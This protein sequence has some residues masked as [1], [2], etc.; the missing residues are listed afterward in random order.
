MKHASSS[1]RAPGRAPFQYFRILAALLLREESARRHAPLESL[2]NLLEPILLVSVMA[3]AR[4][5]LDRSHVS[6]LGESPLLFYATGFFADYLFLYISRRMGGPIQQPGRRFPIEQR[7][8][9][10]IAHVILR[11]M[12]YSILGLIIFGFIYLFVTTDALPFDFVSV[13]EACSAMIMLGFGWGI[14]NVT[15]TKLFWPWAYIG[16]LF[17]RAMVLL[18]GVFFLPDF[19]PP[20][21]RYYI[22]L[23]PLCHGIMLFRMGFYP[24]YPNSMFDPLY[25][26]E[27]AIFSLLAGLMLERITR[28]YE[29]K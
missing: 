11:A 15:V 25:L 21:T 13:A 2:L 17:Y 24:E 16:P 26:A 9:H 3:G 29:T 7:L 6:P 12:D 1:R 14:I 20:E 5:F 27:W 22:G 18:S 19:L 4:H 23:N 8:D 10:I 28:R